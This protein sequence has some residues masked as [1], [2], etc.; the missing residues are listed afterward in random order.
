M[1]DFLPTV[2]VLAD[3]DTDAE[4]ALWLLAAPDGVI[5]RDCSA[6]RAVLLSAG[7][8]LGADCLE[9]RNAALNSVRNERGEMRLPV[10]ETLA[11]CRDRLRA[12]VEQGRAK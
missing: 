9:L 8:R 10:L 2:D 3:L 5:I 7:F 1:S 11:D 4:R 12:V 6:I